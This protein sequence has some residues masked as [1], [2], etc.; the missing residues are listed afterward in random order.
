MGIRLLGGFAKNFEIETPRNFIA[1]P[2]LSQLKRKIF[3]RI[4]SWDNYILFDL[5]AGSGSIAFEALSRGAQEVHLYETNKK[6]LSFLKSNVKKFENQYKDH[7]F[8]IHILAQSCLNINL[9]TINTKKN[10]FYIDPPFDK[11]K[12]YK[13]ILEKLDGEKGIFFIEGENTKTFMAQE[14]LDEYDWLA[15]GHMKTYEKGS[16]YIIMAEVE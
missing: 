10:V 8:K 4:Q 2:T 1:R 12:L 6:T 16:H 11:L 9:D 13:E 7:Q 3:D 15:S 14:L 5:F